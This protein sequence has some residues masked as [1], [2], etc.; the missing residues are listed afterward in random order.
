MLAI[1]LE[2]RL[3]LVVVGHYGVTQIIKKKPNKNYTS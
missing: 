3:E 1:G 2:Y